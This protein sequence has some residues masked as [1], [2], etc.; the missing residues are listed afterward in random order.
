M[1]QTQRIFRSRKK[2][3]TVDDHFQEVA[4]DIHERNKSIADPC[5]QEDSEQYNWA[6]DALMS[7]EKKYLIRRSKRL[8]AL[9]REKNP[10]KNYIER[11][12]R[13]VEGPKNKH[14]L[15]I[16]EYDSDTIFELEQFIESIKTNNAD[17]HIVGYYYEDRIGSRKSITFNDEPSGQG[18]F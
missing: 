11:R 18:P 7:D 12:Q 6:F 4:K 13:K 16:K 8:I 5:E 17:K 10:P 9:I 14:K 1:W 3:P 2:A 15:T